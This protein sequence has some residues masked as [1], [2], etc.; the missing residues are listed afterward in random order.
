MGDGS[1][2]IVKGL[3]SELSLFMEVFQGEDS[4]SKDA[5]ENGKLEVLSFEQIRA[6]TKA[7]SEDRKKLNQRL[8]SLSKELDLNAAKLESLRLVGGDHETTLKRIHELN[9]LGQNISESLNKLDA[10][11]KEARRQEEALKEEMVST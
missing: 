8:E 2:S 1:R 5:F 4:E 9:D 3:K 10:K 6:I 11:L 7:L